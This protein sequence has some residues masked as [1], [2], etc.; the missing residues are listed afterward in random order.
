[1]GRAV[2]PERLQKLLALSG[3]DNEGEATNAAVMLARALRDAGVDLS[4]A[5]RPKPQVVTWQVQQ[6]SRARREY[7]NI[8]RRQ[9]QQKEELRRWAEEK[10]RQERE[11]AAKVRADWSDVFG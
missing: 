3:S 6:K 9:E 10:L 4:E 2:N 1:M 5:L 8:K 11:R 7:E